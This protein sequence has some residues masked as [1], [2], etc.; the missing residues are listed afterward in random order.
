MIS[1]LQCCSSMK[2]DFRKW[3]ATCMGERVTY[4]R[5]GHDFCCVQHKTGV[6]NAGVATF[7][8][9]IVD[10]LTNNTMFEI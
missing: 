10:T 3:F 4:R 5:A 2:T 1:P 9:L 7:L 8:S 6:Q